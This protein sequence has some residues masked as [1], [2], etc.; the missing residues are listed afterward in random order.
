MSALADLLEQVREAVAKQRPLCVVGGNSKKHIGREQAGDPADMG[1]F[2]GV[3]DYQPSELVITV[4]AG[5]TVS[6][7]QKVLA[8]ENQVLASDPPAFNGKAT[9]GGALACNL[10]GPSR[11]WQ[12]SIRDHVLGVR[13]ING[14]AEHLRF[15]GEVMK[16]V[17]GYDVSRLMAGAMGTLGILTEVTLKVAPRPETTVTV[18]RPVGASAALRAMNDLCGTA[19][20]VTGACW[21]AGNMYVRL[22]GPASAVAAAADRIDGS[23][24]PGDR[25]LWSG[26]REMSLPFFTDAKDLWCIS[27]R[28]T[29]DHFMPDADWLLDWRGARRWLAA[30]D[31]SDTLD[32]GARDVDGELWHVRG[33]RNGA[34]VFPDRSEAYRAMLL[35]LKRAFDPA[36]VFNPGRLYSWM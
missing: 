18:C 8:D 34:E 35:R 29:R 33:A 7:L 17:A 10:S 24:L 31:D 1:T 5:T 15:G 36:G 25:D 13:I 30:R 3:V 9:V 14:K 2:A 23:T 26:L 28:S 21:H 4:R 20:P 32:H 19:L 12:G 27:L 6:E 16:N 11:P 22:A